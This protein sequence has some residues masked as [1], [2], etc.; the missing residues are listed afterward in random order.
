V[1]GLQHNDLHEGNVRLDGVAKKAWV[2]NFASASEHE[3]TH[4][5]VI[6]GGIEPNVYKFGCME[7]FEMARA[8]KL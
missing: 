3:C 5:P 8:T 4:Q 2:V 7:L 6:L 1:C